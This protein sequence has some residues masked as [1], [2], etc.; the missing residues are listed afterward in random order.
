[1][2]FGRREPSLMTFSQ[3][4]N[5]SFQE[6]LRRDTGHPAC[7]EL[8]VLSSVLT[9][10][11]RSYQS[12]FFVFPSPR[13]FIFYQLFQQ[14]FSH[15][16]TTQVDCGVQTPNLRGFQIS[17]VDVDSGFQATGFHQKLCGLLSD[18]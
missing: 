2:A 11:L 6:F 18:S 8:N 7:I 5:C 1:M 15:Q 17:K 4:T 13:N 16:F 12:I 9:S 14:W 10:L 3:L